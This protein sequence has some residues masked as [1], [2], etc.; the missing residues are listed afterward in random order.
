MVM[1]MLFLLKCGLLSPSHGQHHFVLRPA[2]ATRCGR[3]PC[4]LRDGSPDLSLLLGW[5][6][7]QH[8]IK[9]RQ[10]RLLKTDVI[11]DRSP[12]EGSQHWFSLHRGEASLREELL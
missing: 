8:R 5:K 3:L 9:P 11:V 12:F 1:P 10:D 6:L 2:P 7:L 4:G